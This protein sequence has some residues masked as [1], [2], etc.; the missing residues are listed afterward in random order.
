MP[1]VVLL[2]ALEQVAHVDR[3][4]A[5]R[6]QEGG[7][8]GARAGGSG[9]CRRP[10]RG[11]HPVPDNDGLE[12]RRGPTG[13]ADRRAA[14]RSG[15]TRGPWA[16]RGRHGAS[17]RRRP[18]CRSSPRG[19]R[20]P[21]RPFERSGE[22]GCRRAAVVAVRGNAEML[23]SAGTPCTLETL[24]AGRLEVSSKV[25]SV[26]SWSDGSPASRDRLV[27]GLVRC[28]DAE[29][30]ASRGA[31][32]GRRLLADLGADLRVTRVGAGLTLAEVA[33]PPGSR[34]PTL[35]RIERG[36]RPLVEA[37]MLL[38]RS[39]RSFGLDLAVRAFPGGNPL[40]DRAHVPMFAAFRSFG[41]RASRLRV[42]GARPDRLGSAS[43]G[44]HV[45]DTHAEAARG[46]GVSVSDAQALARR[47]TAEE[48]G[49]RYRPC[50]PG[51]A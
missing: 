34:R 23:G 3:A 43:V 44:R 41:T 31:R 37:S 8:G 39:A 2:V 19:R 33:V 21:H 30:H 14:R 51:C 5:A 35:S 10:S 13:R 1:R 36:T 46:A 17:P 32:R 7:E 48:A 50:D 16:R 15:R 20:A 22:P 49:L 24:V 28:A 45:A 9:P 4:G 47:V 29:S 18:G 25:V 26:R 11:R 40:R 12:R 6:L 38:R 27:S 42:G